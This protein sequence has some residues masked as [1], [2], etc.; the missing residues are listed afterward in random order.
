MSTATAYL[1]YSNIYIHYCD[2]N[3]MQLFVF[4]Q[5]CQFWSVVLWSVVLIQEIFSNLYSK[6]CFCY[7][8]AQTAALNYDVG[9]FFRDPFPEG[10]TDLFDSAVYPS[11]YHEAVSHDP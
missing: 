1:A 7:V 8:S 6:G 2:L 3:W 9:I 4:L 5:D 11:V 10:P